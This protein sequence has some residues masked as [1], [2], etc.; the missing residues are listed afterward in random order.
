[1]N[2][3]ASKTMDHSLSG[4]KSIEL[5][6]NQI[7]K[8][9][10]I[11]D[12]AY[13]TVSHL[14]ERSKTIDDISQTISDIAEQTSLLALNASIEAARAGEVGKG[15]AVVAEEIGKLAHATSKA[16]TNIT[17][18]ITE[19]QTEIGVVSGQMFSMKDETVKCMDAMDATRD[20]FEQINREIT[21]VGSGIHQ[22]E[23]AV[24]VLN[25]NKEKIVDQFS[26]ISSETQELSA[27][28]Q[29]IMV[30]VEDQ[31]EE[32]LKIENAVQEL[33]QVIVQLNDIMDQFT[34]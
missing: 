18:I 12:E 3:S 27:S 10:E 23:S 16:T 1:M 32:M 33:S 26:D 14:E 6:S 4:V 28:S 17:S 25:N 9:R 22:L 34:I 8:T 31:N 2:H 20:V 29:N 11:Q 7:G 21:E 15:F 24:E 19:I 5:L 13:Q 30:K